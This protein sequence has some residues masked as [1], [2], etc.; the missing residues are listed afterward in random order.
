M[1]DVDEE[2]ALQVKI[3][4]HT[5]GVL[6]TTVHCHVLHSTQP[7]YVHIRTEFEVKRIV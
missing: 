5:A 7:I 6:E 3:C 4:G 2:Q 1:T